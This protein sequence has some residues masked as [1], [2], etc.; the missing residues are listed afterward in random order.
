MSTYPDELRE[1]LIL[2]QRR[3]YPKDEHWFFEDQTVGQLM[4]TLIDL[5]EDEEVDFVIE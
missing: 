4:D 3:L 1:T 2:L 5:M